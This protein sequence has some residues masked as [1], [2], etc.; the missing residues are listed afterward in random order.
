MSPAATRFASA[1]DE[2]EAMRKTKM[3]GTRFTDLPTGEDQFGVGAYVDGLAGFVAAAPTPM[4]VAVQGDWG[5]GKTSFMQMVAVQLERDEAI[6]SV[7][8]NTWQYAQFGQEH[9][10]ALSLMR[11]LAES[12]PHAQDAE[13]VTGKLLSSI[14]RAG[15]GVA[16]VLA[17]AGAGALAG[18]IGSEAVEAAMAGLRQSDASVAVIDP[19]RELRDLRRLFGEAVAKS[20]RRLVV[21]VDDLDRL[22]PTRAVEVM[23]TIKIF[24]DVPDCVFVLAID[25]EV[26][27]QGVAGRF[28]DD[29]AD[30][31]ARAFFD[32][33]IQVPFQLPVAA[34]QFEGFM[35]SALTEVGVSGLGAGAAAHYL[36][37]AQHSVGRNP[38]AMKRLLNT[39]RLLR[40]ILDAT[41]AGAEREVR[42]FAVLCL[43]AGFPSAYSALAETVA[44]PNESVEDL[45]TRVQEDGVPSE[46]K[47]G[48]SEGVRLIRFLLLLSERFSTGTT[49]D[50]KA[51]VHVLGLAQVTSTGVGESSGGPD[52]DLIARKQA[53]ETEFGPETY[54]QFED[55]VTRLGHDSIAVGGLGEGS[56]R[57]SIYLNT[58][59]TYPAKGPVL[60]EVYLRKGGLRINFGNKRHFSTEAALAELAALVPAGLSA[61]PLDAGRTQ[62]L[63]LAG[64]P[65]RGV[66]LV[67]DLM[68]T[69][70]RLV[71]GVE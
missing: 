12:L 28:A 49:L 9:T 55:L 53:I 4:T 61:R 23:E 7:W 52:F 24:L 70:A 18:Q 62:R 46:W 57:W 17:R 50:E 65:P 32:K 22:P 68:Q 59:E 71:R 13:S 58:P 38:R 51:F 64:L 10:L 8:F 34:Y 20:G 35:K 19:A 31:K 26:V 67:V 27:R 42:L 15:V 30:E 40:T 48:E 21:F 3:T 63:V 33:I 66:P 54:R 37:L 44:D 6:H 5:T 25:F 1:T 39:F 47:V 29:V 45:L 60:G 56:R 16:S 69:I 2:G 11:A 41:G 36:E 43:Q 14:A